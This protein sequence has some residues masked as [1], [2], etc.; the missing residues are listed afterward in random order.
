MI[1]QQ[2]SKC[3][4][5]IPINNLPY[6]LGLKHHQLWMMQ[7]SCLLQPQCILSIIFSTIYSLG[8]PEIPIKGYN[9]IYGGV[10]YIMPQVAALVASSGL[11]TTSD[12]DSYLNTL[13][14]TSLEDK[15][16]WITSPLCNWMWS[17]ELSWRTFQ[18]YLNYDRHVEGKLVEVLNKSNY[19]YHLLCMFYVSLSPFLGQWVLKSVLNEVSDSCTRIIYTN[20]FNW[21]TE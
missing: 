10:V 4:S 15:R 17:F 18:H 21:S 11:S 5:V 3:F 6:K 7:F 8:C 19:V 16:Y 2:S 9:K 1:W 20:C 13:S 12:P 14:F